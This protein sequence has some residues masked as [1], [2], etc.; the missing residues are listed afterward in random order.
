MRAM[1]AGV[2]SDVPLCFSQRATL[3]G[4][5]LH[6]ELKRMVV[7]WGTPSEARS[8]FARRVGGTADGEGSFVVGKRIAPG[9]YYSDP[10]G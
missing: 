1:D 2:N 5:R 10:N 6:R 9:R 4:R 3:Q 8:A 7:W